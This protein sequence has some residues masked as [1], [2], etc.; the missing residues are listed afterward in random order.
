MTTTRK[1]TAIIN[2][3]ELIPPQDLET[4]DPYIE[5]PNYD[6][7]NDDVDP[8]EAGLEHPKQTANVREPV[9]FTMD[10]L[11]VMAD[12]ALT[13]T[14]LALV[15]PHIQAKGYTK[16]RS[17]MIE[18]SA[19]NVLVVHSA[20]GATDEMNLGAF[21]ARVTSGSSQAGIG[22]DGGYASYVNYA[23][24]AW[25][26]PPLNQEAEHVEL[27]G[28]ARWTR[29]EWLAHRPMLETLSRWLA[30]RCAVRRIPIVLL[31]DAD[32]KAGKAGICDHDSVSNVWKKSDHWDVGENFP[33]DVV[34]AR[35]RQIAGVGGTTPPT[36]TYH[37]VAKGE[38]LSGIASKYKTTVAALATANG[39]KSPYTIFPG[40]RIK[41]VKASTP[42]KPAP[43][44]GVRGRFPYPADHYFYTTTA[45]RRCHSGYG[46]EGADETYIR[47]IQQ[48]VGA[49]QDG[50]FGPNTRDKVYAWQGRVGLSKDGVFGPMSWAR[51]AAS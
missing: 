48:E 43:V 21:F 34:I 1:K 3:V 28:F 29:E 46:T 38:T 23:D 14:S 39:L 19:V 2:D 37:V 17:P 50:E 15:G 12:V 9:T 10:M 44:T 45:D 31:T 18:R 27:C 42:S 36:A 22:Q 24:T 13:A 26:A 51:A 7:A 47:W 20:E 5:D 25:C 49:T 16:G 33:W 6:E 41:I 35:A 32:L 11:T 30:W 40:Q 4:P 8:N